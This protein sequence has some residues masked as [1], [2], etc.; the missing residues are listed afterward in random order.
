MRFNLFALAVLLAAPLGALAN[1]CCEA[2][3]SGSDPPCG[4]AITRRNYVAF[5][6]SMRRSADACCCTA[7]TV[8][9]CD[10][11]SLAS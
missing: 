8:E 11:V 9:E 3:V 2:Y 10:C 6:D 5:A 1:V 7:P 4:F